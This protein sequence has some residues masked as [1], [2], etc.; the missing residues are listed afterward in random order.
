MT[1]KEKIRQYLSFKGI[2]KNAFYTK[3]GFSVGFLD[4]GKSLGVDKVRV[5]IDNYPDLSLRWLVFDEGDMI[6][7]KNH[8][9]K[10][11]PN[12]APNIAPNPDLAAEPSTKYSGVP[13]V[14]TVDSL[15]NENIP[16][17]RSKAAAG[18]VGSF[19][20]PEYVS[21]L[22]TYRLPGLD[23]ATYRMFEVSGH[24]MRP[25]LAEKDLVIG[26]FV[27][28]IR[29]IREDRV[30][31][32]VTT[33]DLLIKRCLN[34]LNKEGKLICKSDN[35]AQG[36]KDIVLDQTE[37]KEAWY[38]CKRITD[39]LPGPEDI[40]SRISNIEAKLAIIESNKSSDGN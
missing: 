7:D 24:S 5:I 15:G 21:N 11:A 22:P 13:K 10:T 28:D 8:S 34:C 1:E 20:Q 40:Y 36:Y 33:D 16:F 27:E 32:I 30:Y 26:Q 31:I 38:V 4:S 18:Y 17:V 29:T 23:N 35:S 9:E 12:I 19:M 39:Q 3:T 2:S 14:V 25:T 6:V 37:I